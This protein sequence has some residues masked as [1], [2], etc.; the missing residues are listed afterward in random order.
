MNHTY[1]QRKPDLNMKGTA[2]TLLGENVVEEFW[3]IGAREDSVNKIQEVQPIKGNVMDLSTL[4]SKIFVQHKMAVI[5]DNLGTYF[6][7]CV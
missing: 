6:L 7:Q 4:N 5:G 3:D 1:T 2:R